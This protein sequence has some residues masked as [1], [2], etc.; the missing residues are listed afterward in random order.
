MTEE[1]L[2]TGIVESR[3]KKIIEQF[4]DITNSPADLD[5]VICNHFNAA[6]K[7]LAFSEGSEPTLGVTLTDGHIRILLQKDFWR[8][9]ELRDKVAARMFPEDKLREEQEKQEA[10]RNEAAKLSKIKIKGLLEQISN[11]KDSYIQDIKNLVNEII[12]AFSLKVPAQEIQ[13]FF[14]DQLYCRKFIDRLIGSFNEKIEVVV[15]EAANQINEIVTHLNQELLKLDSIRKQN[16]AEFSGYKKQNS[17]KKPNKWLEFKNSSNSPGV[18]PSAT[19]DL[20]KVSP[21]SQGSDENKK[22]ENNQNKQSFWSWSKTVSVAASAI[23]SMTESEEQKLL[24][25]IAGQSDELQCRVLA[26]NL[27]EN[28]NYSPLKIW[29]IVRIPIAKRELS[30]DKAKIIISALDLGVDQ[31]RNE[32]LTREY[33]AVSPRFSVLFLLL[34]NINLKEISKEIRAHKQLDNGQITDL[35]FLAYDNSLISSDDINYLCNDIWDSADASQMIKLATN[36]KSL[37][38]NNS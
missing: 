23:K 13:P 21:K 28:I 6:K 38:W 14:A 30:K 16:A 2:A 20:L 15:P 5:E 36:G 18:I 35:L 27:L 10:Q 29:E 3:A 8:D 37:F 32:D 22:I 4:C 7:P 25:A 31:R 12:N 33:Q 24:N 1:K 34:Q 17:A 11:E 19:M 9:Q 26:A